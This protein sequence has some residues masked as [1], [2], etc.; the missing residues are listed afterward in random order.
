M[1]GASKLKHPVETEELSKNLFLFKFATKRNLEG[2][3]RNGPWSFDRN[4]LVLER[5]SGEEQPSDL[6]MHYG[7]LWVRI[8]EP[9]NDVLE[10]ES[11]AESVGAVELSKKEKVKDDM[12]N[13]DGAKF[14]L[15][16]GAKQKKKKWS[17]KNHCRR[18][19]MRV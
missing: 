4:L 14:T 7:V 8:Y 3:L 12:L 17:Q 19:T 6:N 18:R 10:I 5:V 1:L 16:V 2:V 13:G 11:V 9:R 15:G